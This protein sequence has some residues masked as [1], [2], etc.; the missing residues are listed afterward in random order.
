MTAAAR[1]VRNRIL[2]V[3][4]GTALAAAALGAFLYLTAT[5]CVR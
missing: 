1:I 4:L 5:E 3:L 2:A